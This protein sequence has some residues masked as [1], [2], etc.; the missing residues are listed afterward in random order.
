MEKRPQRAI[1]ALRLSGQDSA[2][3][4]TAGKGGAQHCQRD[5]LTPGIAEI[6]NWFEDKLKP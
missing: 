2:R 6:W 1:L 3:G 4:F 5:Y